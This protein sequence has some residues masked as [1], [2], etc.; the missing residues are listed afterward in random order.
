MEG[1]GEEMNPRE[2]RSFFGRRR[3]GGYGGY[4]GRRYFGKRS[5]EVNK[6]SYTF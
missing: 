4:G 3:F 1:A 6:Y 2:G 5:A